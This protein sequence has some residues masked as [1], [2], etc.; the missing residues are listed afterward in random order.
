MSYKDKQFPLFKDDLRAAEGGKL[1]EGEGPVNRVRPVQLPSTTAAWGCT[2]R[3][4]PPPF[5][6]PRRNFTKNNHPGDSPL[7]VKKTQFSPLFNLFE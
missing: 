1:Q 3:Q 2:P 7:N 5:L 4:L 6:P